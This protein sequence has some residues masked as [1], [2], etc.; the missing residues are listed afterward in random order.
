MF[1]DFIY[2]KKDVLSPIA[3]RKV[4]EYF[5]EMKKLNLTFDRHQLR[6][7]PAHEKKDESCFPME[8]DTLRVEFSHPVLVNIIEGV[9]DAMKDYVLEYSILQDIDSHGIRSCRIQ[10]TEPG[11]GYHRW[12]YES[13]GIDVS[14]R[15]MVFSVY[16]NNVEEGGETEFLYQKKRIPAQEGTV[17]L[18][19]ATYT[20]VHRGN[21]PLSNTKYIA[22]GWIE[23]FE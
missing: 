4:I 15:F 16:L 1:D 9:K 2:V 11:G 6:D 10:K 8:P 13:Q 18:W 23:Y 21:P 17:V 5:D 12:H 14:R 19:P 7:S 20:H 3:C 22:T